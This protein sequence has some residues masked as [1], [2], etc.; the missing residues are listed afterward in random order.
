MSGEAILLDTNAFIYFF[1]GR[2]RVAQLVLH[3]ETVYYSVIT[4]IELLSAGHLTE[5][6][7]EV[8]RE[9]LARCEQVEL[10]S[11]VVRL[12]IDIRR[13][14]RIKT[15]DAIIAASALSLSIPLITADR[16]LAQIPGLNAV[17]DIL[18]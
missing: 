16:E 9:F 4:E 14:R 8:I 15:P 2:R 11:A 1:E 18:D 10:S 3:A 6:E 7:I 12:T 5:R 13:Q 17:V